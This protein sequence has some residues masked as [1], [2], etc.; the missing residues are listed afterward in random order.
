MTTSSTL[1]LPTRAHAI[2]HDLRALLGTE[3]VKDDAPTITAYA[4]DASIYRIPPQAVVL[5]ESE[6]DI[7]ATVAYAAT[8]GIPLTPR[9][10]GTNLTGSAIGSGIILDVSR[11][12]RILEVNREERWARVQ[13]GM[14]LA[15]LNKQLSLQG[16]L[17]GPDPSSGDM[18]K[19][20]GMVANNSSG[21]HTLRYGAVKDNVQSLRLCLASSTWIEARAYA[22]D[23]PS[24]ERLLATVPAL[25][26]VLMMTQAHTDLIAAKRPTVS[27]NSCGYNLFG[28]ADGLARSSFDLPK[29]FVG[30]EGTLGVVSEARLTLVDKPKATLTA[31]IHFRSLEEVGEAVPQ[32]LT[33]QPS[34]LEVMDANTLN[35]IGRGKHGIPADAAATLLI[36]LDA[37]STETDLHE[38][39]DAMAAVCRPYKLAS[40]LTLAFDAE[41]R[42]QLWKA[43]KALY[44]TLYR[45][46]PKKKPINFVDDVVVPAGRISELIRYLENFF[47]GQ[48]VP[49]AIFGHIGNGNAHIV[50]LLD[51][52]DRSDFEKM[53]SAYR[54][55]HTTVLNR[56]GGSICGEHG[57][58]R[59]RAEFVKQMFGEELY[60]LFVQVK[61][62][63]DPGN[64]LNPGIKLSEASFTEHIDY[65]RLSKSCATCAKCNSVC[66][67][68]DVFQSEDMSS[69]G[70][71]EIVTAKDY[72]YLNSKRVVEACL[73]CK[74]CRTI[75][76]AGVDVS[77]LILQKRA[78]HPN[79]LAGWIFRQQA[80]GTAFESF[81][82]FLASTQRIWDRPF[83][84]R[85]LERIT[86]PIMK[87]LAP[88]A[89]LPH[90]LVLPKLAQRHLRERYAH[91]IPSETD[92]PP[93]RSVAYFH[94]CA[95]NYFDDGVGDA[96]I[97]VL[98]KHG[99][100][101]AL[102]PQRC[103]GT[104]IQTYGHIDLVRDGARFNLRSLTPYETIVTGCASCTLML[105]DYPTLFSE[106]TER[107]QAEELSKKVV[108]ISEFVAR[109]PQHPPMA[110]A[111]GTTKRVTY[112]S[113]CHLRAAGVTKE[114]RQVLSSLPGVNF[115]EM[116]DA[117]RC[118]GGAGT[119]LIKDYDTS[120]KIFERKARAIARADADVVATSCPACM[121]QLKNG[122]GDTVRVKHV[123]QL[124]QE[125]YRAAEREQR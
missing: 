36:E 32:L 61:K 42:E 59:V 21:P 118:A 60:D 40:E 92:S 116:Q 105:K 13:P 56:F 74:S 95:A 38:R 106:G 81:L 48:R 96:V 85:L 24:L 53:V 99:V 122:V 67:V 52:N 112:H 27:K 90:D 39:A 79:R 82:R 124:L 108:H 28:L 41:R 62:S 100:E 109:S 111:D 9:A 69:R 64:V 19:L 35:L 121:I 14:V 101:P 117:D 80:K 18:C 44:P 86:T 12:N 75:C 76:P 102:P 3:K 57:D 87:A 119:Y 8:R 115:V 89:R 70:W 77:D 31:L 26:D 58:G 29:L 15:E 78:E 94:G 107:Q 51:V 30:S 125:A 71:F 83:I 63:F 16:L 47:E 10:A 123:A 46:D 17:F 68:Y 88:T 103:S 54:D 66:P 37:D 1:I 72:S 2:A 20:G 97:E 98:K 113:S 55:I 25:R 6:E 93:T 7:A 84:R 22:L 91:L 45:F 34:A 73:N 43:R 4:V 114:P 120:Q 49:V 65:T 5:V 33:L 11:L 104:P 50:P 110:K 23:D